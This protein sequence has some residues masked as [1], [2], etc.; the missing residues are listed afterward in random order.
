MKRIWLM[1]ILV[2][3]PLYLTAAEM[4]KPAAAMPDHGIFALGDTKWGDAPPVLSA[5]AKLAVLEGDPSK[6]GPYTMRLKVPAG[7]RIQPHW[8]TGIEHVTVISGSFHI[9]MGDKFDETAGTLMSPGTFGFL[10]PKMHHFA[11]ASEET[12]IQLHGTGPWEMIYVNPA[13]DPG[14]MQKK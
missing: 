8:H 12:V 2:M 9:G 6:P 1:A 4:Q 7:Y 10:P 11:W 3:L 14:K 5:G 13:D